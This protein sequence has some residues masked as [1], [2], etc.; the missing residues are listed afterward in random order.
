MGRLGPK[1]QSF[2]VSTP[3]RHTVQYYAVDNRRQRGDSPV[4]LCES[5]SRTAGITYRIACRA[6][7]V[8]RKVD[9]FSVTWTDPVDTSLIGAAYYKLNAPPTFATD[10]EIVSAPLG[11]IEDIEVS[12]DGKHSIYVWLVD[13]AGNLDHTHYASVD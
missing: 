10:G 3:G 12:T 6:R 8:G 9:A 1:G 4:P 7:R 2:Q 5:R 11:G 13:N